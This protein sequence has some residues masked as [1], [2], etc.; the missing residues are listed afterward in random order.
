MS[1]TF[2]RVYR[3]YE[4]VLWAA[5]M[6]AGLLTFAIMCVIDLNAFLRKLFNWPLPA[7]LEITQSL[8][9][10]AIMLPFAFTLLKRQHVNTV[11]FT[12]QLSQ[13]ARR[14][15]HLF[16]SVVGFLLFAAVTYGTFRYA[17]RSYQM[18]EQTWGATIQFAIWPSKM[19]VSLGTLLI[20]IQFLLDAIA[21]ALV[22]G[23]HNLQDEDAEVHGDV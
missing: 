23:F 7:A 5:A 8:L 14:Y 9:V 13:R 15:L 18:N 1:A 17:L 16:W 3:I 2:L 20:T 10:G 4:R 12:S 22:P 19:A 11:F 21:T 6:L